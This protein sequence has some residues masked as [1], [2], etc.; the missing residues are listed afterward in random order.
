MIECSFSNQLKV[1][2]T[3]QAVEI[4]RNAGKKNAVVRPS[5]TQAFENI[6]AYGGCIARG[7]DR[8]RGI[9]SEGWKRPQSIHPPVNPGPIRSHPHPH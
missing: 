6:S 2:K 5:R 3:S 7:R 4:M 1:I 9:F 8:E